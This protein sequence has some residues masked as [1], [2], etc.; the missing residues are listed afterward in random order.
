[1]STNE[2]HSLW[3][4]GAC[5]ARGRPAAPAGARPGVRLYVFVII[6]GVRVEPDTAPIPPRGVHLDVVLEVVLP[7]KWPI[8][9][10]LAERAL[11]HLF[12][13]GTINVV[14]L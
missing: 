13:V 7:V 5:S 4:L 3:S 11:E 14:N 10:L 8:L 9:L 2:Q 1:M 6:N 12:L